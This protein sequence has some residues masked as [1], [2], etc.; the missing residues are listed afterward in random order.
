VF[1]GSIALI[2]PLKAG[3]DLGPRQSR[4]RGSPF[5]V[6]PPSLSSLATWGPIVA[7]MADDGLVIT[8]P[9]VAAEGARGVRSNPAPEGNSRCQLL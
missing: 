7:D 2:T 8:A 4:T 6:R 9:S 3:Y 5:L 1:H